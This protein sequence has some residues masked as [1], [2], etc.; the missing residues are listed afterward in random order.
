MTTLNVTASGG[1]DTSSLQAKINA[2]A[3]GD[4]IDFAKGDYHLG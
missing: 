2:A 1:N 4:V 3:A